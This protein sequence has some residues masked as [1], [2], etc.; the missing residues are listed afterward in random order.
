MTTV[1]V[2]RFGLK[3]EYRETFYRYVTGV[4]GLLV[5]FAYVS[6]EEAALWTQLGLSSVTLLFAALFATSTW[7]QVLYPVLATGG[8]LLVW[9]GV[10]TNEQWPLILQAG[11][12]LFGLSTAASK[13]VQLVPSSSSVAPPTLEE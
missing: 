3:P 11:I 13:V 6:Q 1:S 5:A 12:Q 10:V 4:V 9:Y 2:T 7:R 8:A